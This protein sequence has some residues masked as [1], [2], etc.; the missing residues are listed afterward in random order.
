MKTEYCSQENLMR[1]KNRRTGKVY[2]VSYH[3]LNNNNKERMKTCIIE[4]G[5]DFKVTSYN[6]TSDGIPYDKS[7]KCRECEYSAFAKLDSNEYTL[8]SQLRKFAEI[9]SSEKVTVS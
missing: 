4:G 3:G 9:K 2:N 8:L 6:Y 7:I 1:L 5:H